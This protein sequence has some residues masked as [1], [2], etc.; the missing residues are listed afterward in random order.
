MGEP[1]GVDPAADPATQKDQREKLRAKLEPA[2]TET[3][4]AA[5]S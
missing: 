1:I 3:K 4:P 5:K 2:K